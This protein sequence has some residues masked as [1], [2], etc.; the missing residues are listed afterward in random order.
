MFLKALRQLDAVGAA[1][2]PFHVGKRP[3]FFD[4]V[5]VVQQIIHSERKLHGAERRA[6][7]EV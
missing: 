7:A 1:L 5:A 6:D 2:A 3:G 4:D